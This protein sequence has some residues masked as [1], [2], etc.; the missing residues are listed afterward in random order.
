MPA[1]V[2]VGAALVASALTLLVWA[3]FGMRDSARNLVATNLQRG[4][5]TDLREL[6]LSRPTSERA[7]QP[8][9]GQ[10]AEVVRRFAPSGALTSLE[11]KLVLAGRPT[12][13]PLERVLAAKMLLGATGVVIVALRLLGG[14]SGGT[15]L[16]TLAFAALLY[17]T[18]DV[19]VRARAQERQREILYAL[20][21]MLDQ[22]TICM[23]AG[24]GF[25]AAMARASQT[26]G[27]PL[28]QEMIRTLQEV[29]VGVGRR[30]ALQMLTERN[31]VPDLKHFVTA[32]LQADHYGVPVSQVLR[33]Q[34]DE[35]R[36]KRRQRAE[37]AARKLPLKL[38][39][40]LVIFVLPPLF[41]ILVGPAVL[42]LMETIT[43]FG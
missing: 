26:S 20:P 18:P 30:E 37:E 12:N 34:A 39:F 36:A 23:E 40:P 43:G 33:N 35:L 28:A 5:I 16:A 15:L 21:D 38:L 7:L 2:I 29:Q 10:L 1:I 22:M 31:D 25:E 11:R 42:Q 3:L 32:V 13:W 14:A 17:F 27:G 9:V 24:L 41:I 6:T 19:V 4:D 8:L